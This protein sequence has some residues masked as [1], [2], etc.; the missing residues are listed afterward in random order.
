MNATMILMNQAFTDEDLAG[1]TNADLRNIDA[2]AWV[3]VLRHCKARQ[4]RMYHVTT[5]S[6]DGIAALS[7]VADLS[8]EWATKVVSLEPVFEMTNLRRLSVSDFP[9]LRRIDGV[10][11]L[12]HLAELNLSGNRGSLTPP[13][14]LESIE[15]VARLP[16][17]TSFEL[18]NAQLGDDDITPL[19]RCAS[20]RRLSL[21]KGF[22]RRQLA[23]LAKH[24]N[25]RLETRIESHV[26][27]RLVCPTCGGNKAMFTG[28]RMPFLCQACDAKRFSAL[29]AE[30]DRLVEAA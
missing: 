7:G 15:P 11:R 17:L 4:L 29:V 21:S 2:A 28:R 14:K 23:Y 25:P 22:E 1:A 3:R 5:S 18:V 13:L 8:L 30:F 16:S 24:L 26:Q 9:K 27:T 20:L 12:P 10:E 19:A 6:L